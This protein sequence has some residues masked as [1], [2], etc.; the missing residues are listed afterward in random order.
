MS[1]DIGAF[2]NSKTREAQASY[3]SAIYLCGL[4]CSYYGVLEVVSSHGRKSAMQFKRNSMLTCSSP[5]LCSFSQC[6]FPIL[7]CSPFPGR[8]QLHFSGS[9]YVFSL[10]YVPKEV[11]G[12]MTR[13]CYNARVCRICLVGKCRKR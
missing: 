13:G 6:L 10:L 3:A 7:Q 12:A 2:L 11:Q 9:N 5:I 8:T 4:C 1:E